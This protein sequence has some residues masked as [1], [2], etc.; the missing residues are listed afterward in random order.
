M[1]LLFRDDEALYAELARRLVK[2]AADA[3]QTSY[4]MAGQLYLSASGW[5]LLSVPNGLVRAVFGTLD[6]IGV[7]LPP[8]KDDQPFNAHISVMRPEELEQIG[9]ADKITER[10]QSFHYNI[11]RLA[12]VT[13]AGW[14]EMSKCWLLQVNSP[15]LSQ[16]RRSYGLSPLPQRN[17]EPL[18]F[19]ITV[20]V[21]RKGVLRAN[22][23]SKV[24]TYANGGMDADR[25]GTGEALCWRGPDGD[26]VYGGGSAVLFG[27]AGKVSGS[28][29]SPRSA[30]LAGSVGARQSD[31]EGAAC[32]DGGARNEKASGAESVLA[33]LEQARKDTDTNPTE[34]QREAGNYAKG[35]F[36]W[37]G[38]EIS[39][40][41]PKGSTRSGVSPDGHAW[42][43]KMV[44]DYGYI[45][46]TTG[47]DDDHVDVFIGPDLDSEFVAVINQ[48]D[49][50]TGKFDE[51]KVMFGFTNEDDAIEG[52]LANY[53]AGWQG[54]DHAS[55]CT[56]RQFKWWLE[57]GDLTKMIPEDMFAK[58][59]RKAA[60][61]DGTPVAGIKVRESYDPVCPHC[62]EVM[63]EKHFVPD[64]ENEGLYRHRGD[65]YDKG[66]FRIEWPD[67]AERDAEYAAFHKKWID[68]EASLPPIQ[69]D[70]PKGYKKTFQTQ[71]GPVDSI[72]PLDYGY[73]E[74]VINPQDNEE[75]DVFVGSGG[76]RHGRYM[77][78][79]DLTGEWQPDEHKWYTGLTD[80][81]H[82]AMMNWWG[83][84]N[85]DLVRDDTPFEN[86]E[87]LL[88][89]LLGL[90]KQS[91]PVLQRAF[92]AQ[93]ASPTWDK[94]DDIFGNLFNNVSQIRERGQQM[95]QHRH[96][97]N[98]LAVHQNP[99]L[100]YEQLRGI[101]AGEQPELDPVDQ[102]A[103]STELG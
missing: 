32:G 57:F 98:A 68:K 48:V 24:S 72:Y 55:C 101:F 13:P 69:I 5:L 41:N 90:A 103:F 7:E 66:P 86:P 20:A 93:L 79:T 87:S 14:P 37:K 100:G 91:S 77:K 61:E 97:A 81:E 33:G 80:D 82:A 94:N 58:H 40:E 4:A 43:N 54:M 73:F 67:Q 11:G 22:E 23:I 17:N 25:E 75:A 59:R 15:E 71:Q 47:S 42:S 29:A 45:K 102:L 34:A 49:P 18:A 76:N 19:H 3:P 96:N 62:D 70:R 60:A 85:A 65:C 63:Y 83:E 21:R 27:V 26:L 53:D 44:H 6:E 1:S 10:G 74:G 39:L 99:D 88:A 51:H 56:I 52:Y 64:R 8:G 9:G 31:F 36:R 84:Q 95:I 30:A 16:L 50:A 46:G 92:S 38:L 89:D 28:L 35:K 2:T 12:V 78:G